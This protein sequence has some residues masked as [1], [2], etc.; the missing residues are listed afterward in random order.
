MGGIHIEVVIRAERHTDYHAIATVNHLAF[1]GDRGLF[2]REVLLV[3]S[4]RHRAEYDPDLA[5]VAEVGGRVVGYALFSPCQLLMRGEPVK[6]VILGPLCIHPEFQR[7]GIGGRLLLEGHKRA[8]VKGAG[9]CLLYGEKDYYPRFGYLNSAFSGRGLSLDRSLLTSAAG[10]GQVEERPL[11]IADV[12]PIVSMWQAWH[13]DE[14]LAMFPGSSLLDWL[15][16]AEGLRASAI[17]SADRLVGYLR[18]SVAKPW[19]PLS[20][21]A[22]DTSAAAMMLNHLSE[23]SAS[24]GEPR[25]HLPVNPTSPLVKQRIPYAFQSEGRMSVYA[26]IKVLD[27]GNPAVAT[28]CEYLRDES[29]LAVLNLPAQF[30]WA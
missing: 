26:M 15:S 25:I 29:N 6:A 7:Q 16:H 8:A 30:E 17:W 28:Y 11:T 10:Q 2:T 20:F 22:E 18:Y 27:A 19:A 3:D 21:I 9:L 14:P 1:A 23:L 5:L 13:A 4:L 24:S 12:P